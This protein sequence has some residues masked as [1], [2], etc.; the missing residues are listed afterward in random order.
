ML[1]LLLTWYSAVIRPH[2]NIFN[3]LYAAEGQPETIKTS[4]SNF[5]PF[6]LQYIHF[7]KAKLLIDVLWGTSI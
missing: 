6:Y 1:K 5:N 4:I 2:L 3:F 7:L